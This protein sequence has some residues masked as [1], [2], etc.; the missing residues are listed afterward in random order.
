MK[1]T[2]G[3]FYKDRDNPPVP[4]A[5]K[6]GDWWEVEITDLIDFASKH[7]AIRVHPPGFA[8]YKEG[9]FVWVTDG[10]SFSQR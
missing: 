3:H 10:N 6:V 1:F 9:W 4:E 8:P 7:G 2:I 5:V